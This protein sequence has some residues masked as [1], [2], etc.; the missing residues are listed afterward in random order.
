MQGEEEGNSVQEKKGSADMY[1]LKSFRRMLWAMGIVLLLPILLAPSALAERQQVEGYGSYFLMYS[2][3]EDEAL[4]K[5]RARYEALQ[6]AS[7]QAAIFVDTSADMAY[8]RFTRSELRSYAASVLRVQGTPYYTRKSQGEG[9]W[10][11]CRLVAVVD[12]DDFRNISYD[13]LQRSR[14]QAEERERLLREMDDLKFR[15]AHGGNAAE[16]QNIRFRMKQ[17]MRKFMRNE[18]YAQ[19]RYTYDTAMAKLAYNDG[20]D[21]YEKK[22]YGNAFACYQ[23]ALSYNPDYDSAYYGLGKLY[24]IV[25]KDYEKALECYDMVI[26]INPSFS[27]IYNGIAN[28]Y[29][30]MGKYEDALKAVQKELSINKPQDYVYCTLGEIYSAMGEYDKALEA[31]GMSLAMDKD[32]AAAYLFRGLVYEKMGDKAKALQDISKARRL[33]PQDDRAKHHY[34]RLKG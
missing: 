21:Y 8:G 32:Y 24:R 19:T 31:F 10:F 15:Y 22:D 18:P 1:C 7:E 34:E 29:L 12:T 33:N 17:L 20:I 30:D 11:S 4:A 13:S 25:Y 23:K 2:D 6:N 28:V 26:R 9:T 27:G 3:I 14:R 5:E 16:L